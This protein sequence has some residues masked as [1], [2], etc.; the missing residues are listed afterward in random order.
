MN[1]T[2][3]LATTETDSPKISALAGCG[4]HT[5]FFL[6]RNWLRLVVLFV[7]IV[8]LTFVVIA[9]YQDQFNT[10]EALAERTIL[11]DSVGM[12]AVFGAVTSSG[13]GGA[14]W[15]EMW[16]FLTIMLAIG[17]IFLVTRTN[18]A[19]EEQ[20]R[21]ELLRSRPIS[22]QAGLA[23]TV[24]VMVVLLALIA[25]GVALAFIV[26]EVDTKGG[27][28]NTSLL[29]G[30]SI[31]GVALA[32]VGIAL[33]VNQITVTS[34]Q[35]NAVSL[36]VLGGFYAIRAIGDLK[37]TKLTWLSPIGWGE[38]MDPWGN[39][40]WWPLALLT[41]FF[42]LCAVIAFWLQVRRDYGS[43]IILSESGPEHATGWITG[44]LRLTLHLGRTTAIAWIVGL[45]LWGLLIGSILNDMKGLSEQLAP[46][47]GGASLDST[48]ALWVR[49][50]ALI[51]AA[52]VAQQILTLT[53]DEERG[54][55]EARLA[56]SISRLR[57][58]A[59]RLTFTALLVIIALIA[60]GLIM[61]VIYGTTI[62]DMEWVG[63][64]TIA[65]LAYLPS[66]AV[67]AGFAV[68]CFGWISRISTPVT[69]AFV[70]V[71][72]IISMI[73]NMLKIPQDILD[74]I[75]FTAPDL[76]ATDPT[77]QVILMTCAVAIALLLVGYV[78]FRK[79]GISAL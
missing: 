3:T 61:G 73:G 9:Y 79:R 15:A 70:G 48:I 53:A 74:I 20:G 13:M 4:F 67:V 22:R 76:P 25:G 47:S 19:D 52:L 30:A 63:K 65:A 6:R 18:R 26:N 75:P 78:G 66:L 1:A 29:M 38:K 59:A 8:G 21:T 28:V 5:L 77:I 41:G 35:A 24:I 12:K 16:M 57:V 37:E 42:L 11:S 17:C 46:I 68:F 7:V 33:V 45:L 51:V 14:I 32:G 62:S 69:W 50:T 27:G 39:N 58:L 36:A 2:M 72:W 55:L 49:L 54:L 71:A 64:L 56:T 23:A 60:S 43:G 40:L 34:R 10:P 31:S 44:E